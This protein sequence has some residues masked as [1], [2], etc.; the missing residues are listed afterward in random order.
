G[1]TNYNWSPATGLSSNTGSVVTATVT[2]GPVTYKVVGIN[3]T[4]SDSATATLNVYP[5][6]VVT[7]S[8]NITCAGKNS[9]VSVSASG[10]DPGY[11]YSWSN[12]ITGTG[13]GPYSVNPASTTTYS[14]QVT[15]A[16]G[17]TATGADTVFV[18][19]T[20]IG[21]KIWATPDTIMGGQFVAFIDT[22]SNVTSWYWTFGDGGSSV[23]SFPYYQ[24]VQQGVY[25][26]TLIISNPSGCADTLHDTVYVNEGIYVPNVFTPNNDGINDVFHITAG[27]LK[28]YSIEIF[29][30]WGEKLFTANSPNDDWDGRS[31]S[32]VEEA[33]GS[34][35][36]LIKATDYAGKGYNLKGYV[37]LIRN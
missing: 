16:C 2:T 30:R 4:C 28:T 33:D 18:L 12:G 27:S 31:M 14:C 24:Y 22:S 20:P 23:D 19:P 25:P 1:A 3:G 34:Y 11:T 32:G 15:D 5:P 35:F 7:S 21:S 8:S 29:N 37:Q 6:L 17:S 10:G 9:T 26:V 13:P 36:W